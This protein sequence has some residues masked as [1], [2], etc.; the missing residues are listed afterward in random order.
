VAFQVGQI[1][2]HT[3]L[4]ELG[5]ARVEA[6]AGDNIHLIFEVATGGEQKVF[7]LPNAGLVAAPDQSQQ[8]FGTLKA[9]AKKKA[10]AKKKAAA[11]PAAPAQ[12][13]GFDEAWG[14]FIRQYP[15]G[16]GDAK[17]LSDERGDKEALV[18][19]WQEQF[20]PKG[21]AAL[22]AGGDP[23]AVEQALSKVYQG[24]TL[25]YPVEW[26]K[27]KAALKASPVGL[28]LLQDYAAAVAEGSITEARFKSLLGHF[29]ALGLGAGKWTQLTVWPYLASYKGFPFIKPEATKAVAEGMGVA[30]AYEAKPNYP[31]YKKIVGLYEALWSQLEAKGAKD[32]VDLQNFIWLGWG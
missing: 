2:Q 25:L 28:A 10:S 14:R 31:T 5:R 26:V 13:W 23:A 7:R 11:K 6:I 16:F 27:M 18:A 12:A 30:I 32:W 20:G 1:L 17:Y 22:K 3:A 29:E 24:L 19:R 9:A 15:G 21:L 8:G 4:P